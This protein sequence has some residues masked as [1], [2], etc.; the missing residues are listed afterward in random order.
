MKHLWPRGALWRHPDFLKL[1][2]GQTISEFGSQ[3]SLLALPLVAIYV[4]HSS[5][6]AV[7]ALTIFEQL[8]FLLFALPAGVWVDRL[9]RRPI[10]IVGDI[11]RA[12]A[13]ASIPIAYALG[14]LSIGQ[15]FAVAFIVGVLTVF[16]DVAYQSYLPSLVA[17]EQLIDGNS[18]LQGSASVAQLGGPGVAGPLIRLLSAPYAILADVGSFIVSGAFVPIESMPGWM[19]AFA[20]N[21]PITAMINAASAKHGINALEA[22][23]LLQ[24]TE[25]AN[26]ANRGKL[27]QGIQLEFSRGARDLLF[28]PDCSREV[29][30]RRSTRLDSLARAIHT[31][32]KQLTS[33]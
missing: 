11:G 22:P 10:L 20:A 25:P 18:K 32:L 12:L 15:L 4:L 29:R 24:G 30:G 28:P 3:F 17:R 14:E 19:Q 16:F 31:A 2:A 8:P 26:F 1:W 21:Q 6:F 27:A 9:A 13:L 33:E 5:A 7:A 23:Q